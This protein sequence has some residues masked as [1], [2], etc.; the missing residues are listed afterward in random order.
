MEDFPPNW[1]IAVVGIAG[2]IYMVLVICIP[3]IALGI[4]SQISEMRKDMRRF[5][6]QVSAPQKVVISTPPPSIQK[7]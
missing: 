4:Y 5:M 3:F 6:K 1:L 7:K 2:I